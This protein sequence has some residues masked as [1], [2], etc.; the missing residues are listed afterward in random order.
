MA[1]TRRVW[2]E[3]CLRQIYGGQPSDDANISYNLVNVWLQTAIGLAAK[4]NYKENIAIDGIKGIALSDDGDFTWKVTLPEIPIGIGRNEGISTLQLRDDK[5]VLSHTLI[6]ISENQRTY[7]SNMSPIPNRLVYYYQGGS[8]FIVT[9]LLLN[10]Y[11]ADVTMVSGGDSTDLDSTLNVPS[12][13]DNI[14]I[15]YVRQQLTIERQMP[16]DRAND[17]EDVNPTA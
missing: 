11:T 4:A 5:G 2:I 1:I 6:P 8:A 13:Y 17:G 15:E 16:V 12:D 10:D 3:R 9:P 14:M 7:Y